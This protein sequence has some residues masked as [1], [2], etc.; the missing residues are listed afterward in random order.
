MDEFKKKLGR[1]AD[2]AIT[3]N[4]VAVIDVIAKDPKPYVEACKESSIITK[5]FAKDLNDHLNNWSAKERAR[6]LVSDLQTTVKY[7]PEYLD[8]FLVILVDQGGA[9]GKNIA[10]DIVKCLKFSKCKYL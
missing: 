2:N 10:A 8:K 1:D 6:N 5:S 3:S 9:V 7:S 4:N